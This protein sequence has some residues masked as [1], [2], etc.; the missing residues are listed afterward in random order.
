MKPYPWQLV[1]LVEQADFPNFLV[2]EIYIFLQ[3]LH[4]YFAY[5][6]FPSRFQELVF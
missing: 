5:S 4:F 1:S 2:F 6:Q 3:A